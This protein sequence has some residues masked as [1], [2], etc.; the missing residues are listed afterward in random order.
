M[1][2]KFK[3]IFFHDFIREGFELI[4]FIYTLGGG[5]GISAPIQIVPDKLVKQ[6]NHGK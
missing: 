3:I 5:G 2:V 6:M 4:T 1:F